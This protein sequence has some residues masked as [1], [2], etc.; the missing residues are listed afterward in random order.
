MLTPL[1]RFEILRPHTEIHNTSHMR[2]KT[3]LLTAALAAAGMASAM[4]QNVY[5]VNAVGYVNTVVNHG[6]NLLAN[7]LKA[8]D[9]S[10]N[11]LIPTANDQSVIYRFSGG[12]FLPPFTYYTELPGWDPDNVNSHLPTGDGFFLYNPGA[13]F[14]VTWV[15][16]VEQGSPIHND[17]PA[18]FSMKASKVPQQAS[19]S[20]LG[21]SA[22]ADQTSVY[23]FNSASQTYRP[24]VTYYT[25][26]PGWDPVDP[27][28]DIAEGFWLNSPAAG[29]WTRTFSVN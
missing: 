23:R 13:A 26:L 22:P 1:S 16:E 17:Y 18:G 28:I 14:T 15:G 12:R 7:P 4:A 8:G 21:L 11:V 24:T 25:E 10:I 27:V 29:D 3:L 20:A 19:L 5:S 9:D 6:F 2:T